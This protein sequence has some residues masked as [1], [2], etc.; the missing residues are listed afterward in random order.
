[1][2]IYSKIVILLLFVCTNSLA[3][4]RSY[5]KEIN[6]KVFI[7]GETKIVR[8]IDSTKNNH[9]PDFQILIYLKGELQAK[10]RWLSFEH[11]ASDKTNST[12]V[13]LSNSYLPTNAALVFNSKGGLENVIYHHK[14]QLEYCN[15]SM[16]IKQWVS[17]EDPKIEF[18]Y[19]KLADGY[20]YVKD[21]TFLNC[22]G[23]RITL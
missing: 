12:F 15:E 3:D 8:V 1:M 21:I 6:E 7:F 16:T 4:K 23:E 20:E 17:Q 14:A 10:Y 9:I 11:I 2:R 18:I 19:E 13:A 22:R 5:K